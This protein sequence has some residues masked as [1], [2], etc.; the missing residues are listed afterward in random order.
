[1]N[2]LS[3]RTPAFYAVCYRCGNALTHGEEECPHCGT[4]R[5]RALCAPNSV[6]FNNGAAMLMPGRMFVPYPSVP[7]E[8]DASLNRISLA[9]PLGKAL[10]GCRI[11]ATVNLALPVGKRRLKIVQVLTVHDLAAG[12]PK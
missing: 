11:G 10:V 8:V 12:P 5:S 4:D 1:M 6:D 3:F 7:E 9:S 2:L